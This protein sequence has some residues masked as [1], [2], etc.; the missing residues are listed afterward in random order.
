MVGNKLFSCFCY[1][2]AG[3]FLS[4]W[5]VLFF[6][7]FFGFFGSSEILVGSGGVVLVIGLF[8]FF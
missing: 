7:F 4:I 8:G 5:W 2:F 6:F 3:F 1:E